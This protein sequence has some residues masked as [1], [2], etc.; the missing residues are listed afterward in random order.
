MNVVIEITGA[1][2]QGRVFL[3]WTPVQATA[4]LVNGG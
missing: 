4:R 2:P 3:T 1:D